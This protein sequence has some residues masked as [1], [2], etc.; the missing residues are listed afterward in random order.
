MGKKHTLPPHENSAEVSQALTLENMA[1]VN[2]VIKVWFHH[3]RDHAD[4]VGYGNLGLA[5]AAK[6]FDD[7]LGWKFSTYAVTVI[8]REILNGLRSFLYAIRVPDNAMKDAHHG[9][10]K[11]TTRDAIR[12]MRTGQLCTYPVAKAQKEHY[13]DEF[14]DVHKAMLTMPDRVR[15]MVKKHYGIGH[16]RMTLQEIA[17]E[18]KLSKERVRQLIEKGHGYIRDY[19]TDK[20]LDPHDHDEKTT[21]LF[22]YRTEKERDAAACVARGEK[23]DVVAYGEF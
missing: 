19:Y 7:S 3:S 8:R 16:Q 9:L 22:W 5:I 11:D 15:S 21:R 2:Y 12:A 14:N 13:F 18:A 1:L 10:D 17:G 4:L 20:G 23:S 6:R